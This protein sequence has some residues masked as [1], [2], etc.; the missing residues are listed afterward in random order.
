MPKFAWISSTIPQLTRGCRGGFS[1]N[2]F[3]GEDEAREAKN[4]ASSGFQFIFTL[5][6]NALVP[7]LMRNR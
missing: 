5:A 2:G 6:L 3:T 4:V 7:Q 1:R